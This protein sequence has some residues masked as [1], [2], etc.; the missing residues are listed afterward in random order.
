MLFLIYD[1]VVS[2]ILLPKDGKRLKTF[3]LAL[4]LY[5]LVGVGGWLVLALLESAVRGIF[6]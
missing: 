6:S 3:F 2:V 1:L 4:G 5:L